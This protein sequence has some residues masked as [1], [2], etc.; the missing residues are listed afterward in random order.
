MNMELLKAGVIYEISKQI[1][2]LDF[3]EEKI[4]NIE[5]NYLLSEIYSVVTNV[6]LSSNQKIE[7]ISLLF[8]SRDI[9]VPEERK[10]RLVRK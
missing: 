7:Q 4:I 3:D 10:F 9:S 6:A 2:E 1:D 8:K 5:S